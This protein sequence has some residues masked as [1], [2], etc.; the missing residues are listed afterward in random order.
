MIFEAILSRAPVSAIRL[1]PDLP[2]ELERIIN[3]ALEND[4]NLRYQ[5]ASEMRAELQRLKR[6]TDS[7]R[8]VLR[9]MR[10]LL[11]HRTNQPRTNRRAAAVLQLQSLLRLSRFPPLR[12]V[13]PSRFPP[14]TFPGEAK[15]TR[16]AG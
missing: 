6:D 16:T 4:R 2:A 12:A 8:S 10:L 3:R 9:L 11:H 7:S 14:Q 1:N 5:H 15:P 13:R